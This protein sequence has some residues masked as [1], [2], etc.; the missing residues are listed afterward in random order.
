MKYLKLFENFDDID[1]ICRK[2]GINN[3]II[4]EDGSIDVNDDVY[5]DYKE[6]IKLPLKFR[7]VTGHF[8]CQNNQLTSL[9]G[10]P[11]SVGGHV[12]NW[13][14][15]EAFFKDAGL[16]IPDKEELEKYYTIED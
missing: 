10:S 14:L 6:L 9:E 8:Y 15:L 5:L 13:Y 16:E 2:Y 3:Y 4:N 11:K 12:I 1:S 7:N